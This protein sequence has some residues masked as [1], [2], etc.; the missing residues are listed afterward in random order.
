MHL[1][2]TAILTALRSGQYNNCHTFLWVTA[3]N[4]GLIFTVMTA[5]QRSTPTD[6]FA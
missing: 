1:C 5:R 2:G 3:N 4:Y 6:V